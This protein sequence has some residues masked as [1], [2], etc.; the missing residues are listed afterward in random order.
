MFDLYELMKYMPFSWPQPPPVASSGGGIMS[1]VAA[2]SMQTLILFASFGLFCA[3]YLVVV[4]VVLPLLSL[5]KQASRTLILIFV[6]T[7]AFG[8]ACGLLFY[9][10]WN[11]CF[12]YEST[13]ELP[14]KAICTFVFGKSSV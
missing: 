9:L 13:R 1:L 14:L 3:S 7:F 8:C 10:A 2:Q 11:T 6:Y 5:V 12:T 4:H